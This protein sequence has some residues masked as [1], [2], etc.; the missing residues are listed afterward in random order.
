MAAGTAVRVVGK[1]DEHCLLHLSSGWNLT[2]FDL[3]GNDARSLIASLYAV[4]SRKG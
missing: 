2:T 4:G 3:G 1:G